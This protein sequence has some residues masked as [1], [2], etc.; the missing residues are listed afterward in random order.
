M[1]CNHRITVWE[2][3]TKH[4]L[5]RSFRYVYYCA[6]YRHQIITNKY[7]LEVAQDVDKE[8]LLKEFVPLNGQSVSIKKKKMPHK[9]VLFK[10]KLSSY[11]LGFYI[12][13][14]TNVAFC[15]TIGQRFRN[16]G[17]NFK[18]VHNSLTI[19]KAVV[20][21]VHEWVLTGDNSLPLR[22]QILFLTSNL[23]SDFI[24]FFF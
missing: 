9:S 24:I 21:L 11:F 2:Q 7:I 12:W 10:W 19:S 23:T 20:V 17:V 3:R 13:Y 18:L 1:N 4:P 16:C 8:F 22:L 15:I 5:N 14:W 6:F